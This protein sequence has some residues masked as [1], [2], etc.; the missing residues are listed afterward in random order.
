MLPDDT[1]PDPLRQ[2]LTGLVQEGTLSGEQARRVDD[3]LRAARIGPNAHKEATAP[4]SSGAADSRRERMVEVFS[5]LGGAL[6]I[7]A[8]ILI[9]GLAWE[10]LSRNG[11]LAICG[12]TSLLMLAAATAIGWRSTSLGGADSGGRRRVHAATLAAVASAGVAFTVAIAFDADTILGLLPPG[13]GMLVVAVGSYVVWRGAPLLCAIFAGGLLVV[14]ALLDMRPAAWMTLLVVGSTLVAYGLVWIGLGRFVEPRRVAAVL[15][16]VT[17]IVGAELVSSSDEYAG[18]GLVLG[19][20]VIGIMFALLWTSSHWSYAALGAIGALLV[21][22]TALGVLF[23]DALIAGVV[24][25]VI[26]ILLI[27]GAVTVVRRR[28]R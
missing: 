12:G 1:R 22:P 21:P 20:V 19:L 15:G 7:G 28:A 4:T 6:V 10:D 23:D 9:V 17:G 2:A 25:L 27:V 11:Q 13:I 26:G 18:L 14:I 3:V 8:L 24:L 5:Y 16:G